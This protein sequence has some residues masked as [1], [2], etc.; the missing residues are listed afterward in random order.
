MKYIKYLWYLIRHKWFVMLECF[1]V[2]LY[3]R[4]ITHDLSKFRLSEFIPYAR[5]FSGNIKTGRDKTGYYK[6]NN[7]G[8][9]AFDS[10]WFLHQK[11]NDHHWQYW[12]M[13]NDDGTISTFEMPLYV[14]MEMVCDW[15][16]AGRAQ[17]TPDTRK[18]Y[19][20]NNAKLRLHDETRKI[21]E[22]MIGV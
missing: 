7:T 22:N 8:D 12:T 9:D 15:K 5:H 19:S 1:S 14:V 13:P 11:R 4:G 17:G 10:A 6:P 16:G 3:Y 21:V 20:A 18:W 2:G